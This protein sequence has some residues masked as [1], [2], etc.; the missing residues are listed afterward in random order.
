MKETELM[1]SKRESEKNDPDEVNLER[2]LTTDDVA[3]LMRVS[4]RHIRNLS[5]DGLFPAPIQLGRSVRY[6]PTAVWQFMNASR[7]PDDR[8]IA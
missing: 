8:G 5:R 1:K 4:D 6:C 3:A 7:R 2:L